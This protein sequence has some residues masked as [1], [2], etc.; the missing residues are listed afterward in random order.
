M[1]YIGRWGILDPLAES[2]TRVSPY[3]YALNNPVMFVDPDGRKAYNPEPVTSDIPRGGLLDF[4]GNGGYTQWGSY[5][6]FIGKDVFGYSKKGSEGVYGGGNTTLVNII[7]NF[8]RGDEKNLG[9]FVNSDFE[10]NG[11]HVIDASSLADALMKLTK[12]LGNNQADNIYIN[13]HGLVGKR[14]TFDE[15]GEALRDPQ[16]GEY[17]LKDDTG[18][19]TN[20]ETE[21]IY[22]TDIQQYIADSGKLTADKKSSIDSLVGI[23]DYV[24][25]GKNLIMGA[26]FSA[27][28][29]LFGTGLSSLVKSRDTFANRDYSS[30]FPTGGRVIH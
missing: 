19:Y 1:A 20:I 18:F 5:E 8:I 21:K 28:E 26:C 12:Y 9:N 27:N 7:I 16:T 22:G 30:L 25:D 2:T 4:F 29:T 17:I 6:E 3:N 11:W 23:G 15:K 13:A 24:R 14:Y 10:N